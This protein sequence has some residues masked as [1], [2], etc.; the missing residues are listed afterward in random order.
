MNT[1]KCSLTQ[2]EVDMYK[3]GLLHCRRPTLMEFIL[4]CSHDRNS[5]FNQEAISV[6]AEDF[7]DKIKN[8]GWYHMSCIPE[9]YKAFEIVSEAFKAHFMYIKTCYREVVVT[10]SK[11]PIQAKQKLNL[12]LQ[13]S[14]HESRKVCVCAVHIYST[15]HSL[16]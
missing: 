5:L 2:E 13:K 7:I 6:F 9:R 16:T 11:D 3:Q 12:K 14:S 4:D 8:H 15:L 10:P 1:V